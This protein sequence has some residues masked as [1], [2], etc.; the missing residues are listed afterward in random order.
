[1]KTWGPIGLN[2]EFRTV[3]AIFAGVFH[4]TTGKI[5]SKVK[6][7]FEPVV[8]VGDRARCEIR[9]HNEFRAK[10]QEGFGILGGAL[11]YS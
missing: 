5:D 9:G 7:S 11:I 4:V 10:A 3:T 2:T 8:A 6:I 1:V